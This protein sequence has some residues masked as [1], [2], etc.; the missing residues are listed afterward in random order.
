MADT[1]PFEQLGALWIW[2]RNC[3]EPNQ[4]VQ[5]QHE[6]SIFDSCS[7][8]TLNIST[9]TGYALWINQRFVHCGQFHDW[10]SQKTYDTL[11]I[12][13]YLIKGRNVISLIAYYQGVNSAQYIRGEPGL[14]YAITFENQKIVSG[15]DVPCRPSPGYKVL[16]LPRITPQLHF[17]FEFDSRLD[18]DWISSGYA[19]DRS[20]HH[21]T[22][23]E[24][25]SIDRT[26]NFTPRPVKKILIKDRLPAKIVA[27]GVF[28]RNGDSENLLSQ[29]MYHDFLSCRLPDEVFKT[30][31]FGLEKLEP[32]IIRHPLVQGAD[33]TYMV[34]DLGREE[35]GLF[36]L[37]IDANDG[38]IIDLAYGEHLDDLRVRSITGSRNFASRYIAKNGRQTFTHYFTRFACRYIQLHISNLKKDCTLHYA[39][40]RC[41]EYPIEIN[42]SFNSACNLQ[43][44]I[45]ST[46]VRTLH[47]CMHEH[48]EDCPWREQGLLTNDSRNQALSGY[49]CFGE[50]DFPAASLELL[51]RGLKPDGYL[52]LYAPAEVPITIPSFS[53]IWILA[54]ADHLLYSG[55]TEYAKTQYPAVRTMLNLWLSNLK[56][57]ILPCPIGTRYW[58]FYD[59]ASG[60]NAIIDNDCTRFEVLTSPRY[61]APL[62]LLLCMALDA[63]AMIA[64]HCNDLDDEKRF[65]SQ[66]ETLRNK[67]KTVFFD[68]AT[69]LYT[70]YLGDNTRKGHYAQLT[71]SFALLAGVCSI[72]QADFIRNKLACNS[73]MVETT[74]SQ[75]FYK[76]KA[77][78]TD[79]E[80]YGKY[81]FDKINTDWGSMLFRG[82]TSF[83]ETLKGGWDFDLAGSLCHGW[84]AIPVYFYYAHL[85]GIRPLSPGFKKFSIS[86]TAGGLPRACGNVPTPQGTIKVDWKQEGSIYKLYVEYPAGLV[87]EIC[88]AKEFESKWH[89]SL[90]EVSP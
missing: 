21:I 11:K 60:L 22:N 80:H 89:I 67:I 49:Y 51:G 78:L 14:I 81:V 70:T 17:T 41:L 72:E 54:V 74:L 82:A 77:M 24:A 10:P 2:P 61:D 38:A 68:T 59:W 79:K 57:G 84:S 53:M 90:K 56:D 31:S 28:K 25:V 64:H 45:Y 86:P 62:N 16:D 55:N 46:S 44:K 15:I 85:L 9:D 69:G 73:G 26:W 88:H 63:G 52:E 34:I 48:Y 83:W 7:N 6:F 76:F 39:G 27:Q 8:G 20:W 36:E 71:Q 33:G 18:D 12:S 19:P 29:T 32:V 4:Y 50:Y 5:F 1:N 58:H 3:K 43:N 42:G 35:V 87:P 65:K 13:D 40:L 37:D 23:S 47:L 75:S 66:A 30:G